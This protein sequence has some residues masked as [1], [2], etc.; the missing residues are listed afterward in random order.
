MHA[1]L[2]VADM[3]RTLAFYCDVLGM[4]VQMSR[5]D[6]NGYRNV[7]I[8]YGPAVSHTLLEFGCMPGVTTYDK[9]TAFDHIAFE[10]GELAETCAHL[11]TQGVTFVRDIKTAHSGALIAI[12]QDPDGYRIELVQPKA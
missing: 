7:F 3:D 11:R 4:S 9:G 12:I 8:G 1:M 6:P 10:V 5:T 2:R